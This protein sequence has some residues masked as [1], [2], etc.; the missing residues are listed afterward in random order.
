ML[1]I[2]SGF[3]IDSGQSPLVHFHG[4][5]VVAYRGLPELFIALSQS[6]AKTAK[7]K[8]VELAYSDDDDLAELLKSICGG[9]FFADNE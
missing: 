2:P 6:K 7:K 1:Y 4:I 5:D 8:V 3:G 9:D